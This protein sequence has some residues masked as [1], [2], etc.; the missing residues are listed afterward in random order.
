[1]EYIVA[2][3]EQKEIKQYLLGKLDAAGRE[4]F[5]Q[6]VITDPEYKDVVLMIE[7]ELIED[8]VAGGLT[9]DERQE[10]IRHFLAT[11]QQRQRVKDIEALHAYFKHGANA[12]T[13]SPAPDPTQPWPQISD[14]FRL[15]EWFSARAVLA[16]LLAV[17][18]V[19]GLYVGIRYLRDR[20]EANWSVAFGQEWARLNGPQNSTLQVPA[21]LQVVLTPTV[22]RGG[23]EMT[24]VIAPAGTERM[25]IQLRLPPKQYTS[26]QATLLAVDGRESFPLPPL[27][28]QTINGTQVLPLNIPVKLLPRGD[29]E[30]EVH[31][32]GDDNPDTNPTLYDFRLVQ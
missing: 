18:L 23:G 16:A 12:Q 30:L 29:Y 24:R 20:S 19:V 27:S 3:I 1:M 11:P 31:G 25:Q 5:E 7:E 32:V 8:F 4:R 15:R 13:T 14:R 28:P 22:T 10:F 26:Y 21:A 9:E 17:V 2:D 6:R